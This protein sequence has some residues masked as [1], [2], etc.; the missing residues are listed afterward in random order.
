MDR[1]NVYEIRYR[2]KGYPNE[3]TLKKAFKKKSDIPPYFSYLSKKHTCDYGYKVEFEIISINRIKEVGE[4][5]GL[6]KKSFSG[7][8]TKQNKLKPLDYQTKNEA[9]FKKDGGYKIYSFY[10]N[11]YEDCLDVPLL[12]TNKCFD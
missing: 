5:F 11:T 3:H 12:L 9:A 7:Q 10:E 6:S 1:I 2:K 8:R 4:K